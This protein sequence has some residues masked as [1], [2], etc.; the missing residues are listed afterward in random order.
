MK[1]IKGKPMDRQID[2]IG[3]RELR[4]RLGP[5]LKRISKSG[6]MAAVTN[7]NRIEAVLVPASMFDQWA[8]AKADLERL[9]GVMPLLMAAVSAGATIPSETLENLELELPFDWRRLN[10]L[11]AAFPI[12]ISQDEQGQPLPTMPSIH[13]NPMAESDEELILG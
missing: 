3:H 5:V 10:A 8:K 12:T 4:E 1:E 6:R 2:E 13:H 9:K 11:Q 7:R